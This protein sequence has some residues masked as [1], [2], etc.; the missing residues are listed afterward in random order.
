ML[1]ERIIQTQACFPL[2]CHS[3]A[4]CQ[5]LGSVNTNAAY[6]D[7]FPGATPGP[8]AGGV[9]LDIQ[10][11]VCECTALGVHYHPEG[12]LWALA[13]VLSPASPQTSLVQREN[14]RGLSAAFSHFPELKSQSSELT[15]EKQ[16]ASFSC[17]PSCKILAQELTRE[18]RG[19]LAHQLT[20][21]LPGWAQLPG[22]G[23]GPGAITGPS[24]S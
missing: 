20:Y 12:R 17:P 24:G 21:T 4:G 8:T 2:P 1:Q 11:H 18:R 3:S 15:R 19:P 9:C 16:T 23:P 7:P 22:K 14:T 13:C 6:S 5:F 10:R